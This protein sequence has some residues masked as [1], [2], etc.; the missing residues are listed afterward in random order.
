MELR[1]HSGFLSPSGYLPQRVPPEECQ[2]PDDAVE[3]VGSDEGENIK[4]DHF[5]RVKVGNGELGVG[6]AARDDANLKPVLGG[7]DRYPNSGE[8]MRTSDSAV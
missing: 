7:G 3:Q 8:I 6:K 2:A 1:V 4:L 5:S